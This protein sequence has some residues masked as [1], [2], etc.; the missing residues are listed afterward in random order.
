MKVF[1]QPVILEVG[2]LGI[3]YGV[4]RYRDSFAFACFNFTALDGEATLGDLHNLVI[5][6]AEK[7][8]IKIVGKISLRSHDI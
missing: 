6:V 7:N 5:T 8:E 2:R 1:S 3:R 4:I